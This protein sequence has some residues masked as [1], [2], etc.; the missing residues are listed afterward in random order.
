[1]LDGVIDKTAFGKK[2]CSLHADFLCPK[3]WYAKKGV[4]VE[5]SYGKDFE[6]WRTFFYTGEEFLDFIKQS[7]LS[8]F[9]YK[10]KNRDQHSAIFVYPYGYL[11]KSFL[12]TDFEQHK[13]LFKKKGWVPLFVDCSVNEGRLK[14]AITK[15]SIPKWFL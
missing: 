8:R 3:I 1:M 10:E 7:R 14:H 12:A 15:A 13:M 6:T 9:V 2:L 11:K 4:K 5:I